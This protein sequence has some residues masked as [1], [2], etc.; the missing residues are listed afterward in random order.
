MTLHNEVIAVT[1][2]EGT[3][4][5]TLRI[6]LAILLG[7]LALGQR[8]AAHWILAVLAGLAFVTGVTGVCGL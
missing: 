3:L 4:D 8:G 7:V 5:R 6:A 2:N 1:A